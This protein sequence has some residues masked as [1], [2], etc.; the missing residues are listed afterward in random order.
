MFNN[1]RDADSY[2]AFADAPTL[3]DEVQEQE[4]EVREQ[5]TEER[6]LNAVNVFI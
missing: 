2:C 1:F 5:L 6:I 4:M 3:D